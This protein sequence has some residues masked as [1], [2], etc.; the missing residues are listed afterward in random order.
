MEDLA[1][2]GVESLVAH[3]AAQP[4]GSFIL[5]RGQSVDR[6][7]LPKV[8]RNYPDHDSTEAEKRLL[9]ELRQR[10]SMLI[11]S[12]IDDWDLLCIAQHHG[13]ATRLLDWSA[14]PLVAL[15]MALAD[16]PSSHQTHA[17]V[18]SFEVSK[19]WLLDKSK[20]GPFNT[21]RTRV[22]QPPLN[23]HRVAAQSGWFTAHRFNDVSDRT[24]RCF[25]PLE[26]QREYREKI[27]R[28]TIPI[29]RRNRLLLQLHKLGIDAQTMFPGLEGLCR[30][31][32][33]RYECELDND[34]E[35]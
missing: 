23:N 7:L 3:A 24:G 30:H 17:Y 1:F 5:Y 34:V 4:R 28:F 10:G 21:R 26:L 8:A 15:W 12:E 11:D 29:G 6:P 32:S 19:A 18:Y 14:N 9:S 13:A 33:W 35:I 2:R 27:S 16:T 25:V 31:M 20:G 22:L